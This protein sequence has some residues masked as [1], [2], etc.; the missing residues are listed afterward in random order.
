MYGLK[1]CDYCVVLEVYVASIVISMVNNVLWSVSQLKAIG[2]CTETRSERWKCVAV[3][4]KAYIVG[5]VCW[6][7]YDSLWHVIFLFY[8]LRMY[9]YLNREVSVK[10]TFVMVGRSR[11]AG[12]ASNVR[13]PDV[14]SLPWG[15]NDKF[16][17]KLRAV[18]DFRNFFSYFIK[19]L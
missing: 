15:R 18:F 12:E 2:T 1:G 5:R 14:F 19:I 6:W 11:E 13:W 16:H 3:D 9:W 17:R 8:T 10:M 4:G 7:W